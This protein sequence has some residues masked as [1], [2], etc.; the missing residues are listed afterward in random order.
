MILIETAGFLNGRLVD[1][2]SSE[3]VMRPVLRD[4]GSRLGL[5]T[6]AERKEMAQAD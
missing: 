3:D 1:L 2:A 5:E 4:I 6:E